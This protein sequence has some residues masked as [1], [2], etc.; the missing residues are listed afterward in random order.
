MSDFVP[1]NLEKTSDIIFDFSDLWWM[2]RSKFERYYDV[3]IKRKFSLSILNVV[4]VVC[5]EIGMVVEWLV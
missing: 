3:F 4:R 2:E 5:L 1:G